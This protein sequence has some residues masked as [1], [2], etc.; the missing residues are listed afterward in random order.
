MSLLTSSILK[1]EINELLKEHN[2]QITDEIF[3]HKAPL[4]YQ[5]QKDFINQWIRFLSDP[6]QKTY[7]NDDETTIINKQSIIKQPNFKF[8]S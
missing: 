2:N 5:L 4:L 1:V 3:Q 6:T 7:D 8:N